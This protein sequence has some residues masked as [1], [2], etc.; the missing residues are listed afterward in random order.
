MKKFSSLLAVVLAVSGAASAAHAD[1]IITSTRTTK[2]LTAQAGY[3]LIGG[4]AGTSVDVVT[5]QIRNDGLN[6]SATVGSG[7]KNI[8]G[9]D[10]T[11]TTPGVTSATQMIF[12]AIDEVGDGLG[13]SVDSFA[14]FGTAAQNTGAFGSAT[15]S[16]IRYGANGAFTNVYNRHAGVTSPGG[17][18]PENRQDPDS[19]GAT[20]FDPTPNYT[21]NHAFEVVGGVTTAGGIDDSVAIN[22]GTIVVPVGTTVS[23]NGT[24]GDGNGTIRPASFTNSVT[25]VPEP[26]SLSLLALGGAALL[27]RRRKAKA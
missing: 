14:E 5:F 12:K 16:Y 26:A 1:F 21:N 23:I 10:F 25:S 20:T 24:A 17:I 6:G 11:A 22:L 3:T 7:A 4:T 15:G 9:I 18:F 8:T 2:T 27:T 19:T 13:M